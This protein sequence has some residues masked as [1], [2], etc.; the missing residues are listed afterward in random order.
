MGAGAQRFSGAQRGA[1]L[2]LALPVTDPGTYRV[3]L[4]ATLAPDFGFVQCRVNDA[5]CGA[6]VD[7]YAPVVLPTGAIPLGRVRLSAG[8][9]RIAF[10][11]QGKHA[12]SSGYHFGIDALELV[13][14]STE[15]AR[16]SG[17]LDRSP[18]G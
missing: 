13:E 7:L 11:V 14:D 18:P 3:D 12:E 15:L 16:D 1:V 9:H 17:V 6:P 2:T 8:T 10:E 4:Y 5:A